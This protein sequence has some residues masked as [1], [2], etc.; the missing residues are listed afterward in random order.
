VRFGALNRGAGF[1]A[2]GPESAGRRGA[3]AESGSTP[4][5][6]RLE[7]RREG[8]DDGWP[9]PVNDKRLHTR[10]NSETGR[11]G[12]QTQLEWRARRA[13]AH[14]AEENRGWQL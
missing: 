2:C 8:G 11:A 7:R 14:W 6:T 10:G 4:A 1:L 13:A 9:P 5:R 12:P 3:D